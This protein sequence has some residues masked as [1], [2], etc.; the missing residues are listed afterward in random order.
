MGEVYRARD[1]KLGRDVAIK[2]LSASLSADKAR[3][4]RFEQEAR[5]T[6]SLN[7]PNILTV[8]DIGTDNGSPYIVTELLEGEE[9]RDRLDA[10]SPPLRKAIDYAQQ[11]VNGLSAAHGKGI[12]HRDLKP[13]NLFITNDDRVKILDFGLAKLSESGPAT[14]SED[15][16]RQPKHSA[17]GRWLA[18]NSDETGRSEIYVQSFSNEGKLGSDRKLIS[19]AGGM[20]PVWRADGSELF[21]VAPD[22]QMMVAAVKTDGREFEFATPKALFK[23]RMMASISFHE[24]DVTPDGQRFLIGTLIG[25]SKAAPPTVIMNWT[26]LL[27]K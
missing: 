17:N 4:A 14:G 20:L 13:E 26:A 1:S 12:V 22:G 7:H 23:T 6:S 3:L 15:A 24:F 19:S 27:K 5:T 18:Y 25:E 2:V 21:F 11:I 16:T 8:Y 10:G 9:L